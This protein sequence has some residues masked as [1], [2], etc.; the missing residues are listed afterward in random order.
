MRDTSTYSSI[1][2]PQTL[3]ITVAPRAR[4]SGIFSSM[5]R[6][7]PIPCRP[8]A[9]SMPDGVSTMRG[10]GCPSRA[11]EKQALRHDRAEGRQI[12]DV[13]V[14]DAVAEAAARGNQRVLEAERADL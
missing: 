12:D 9:F 7:A 1:V 6:R 8:I 10:A 11:F 13:G 3:T 5:K 14:L 2:V 4:S